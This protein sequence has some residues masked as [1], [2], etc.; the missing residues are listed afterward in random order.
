MFSC[1]RR[2]TWDCP[3][4][5]LPEA[6]LSGET[7]ELMTIRTG[8]CL[9][10]AVNYQVEGEP[11]RAGLCHCRN[12]KRE[13]GSSFTSY[14]VWPRAAFSSSGNVA[15]HAGQS[16][17]PACGSPLFGLSD[18]EAEIKLG[19]LDGAPT[20]IEPTYELW[21]KRRESWLQPLPHAEQFDEDRI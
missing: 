11:L 20:D 6:G 16:F 7:E 4:D 19:S 15:T 18:G 3:C 8:R 13:S 21:V 12:C 10:G 5:N 1:I 9:C 17:C 2:F 14:G